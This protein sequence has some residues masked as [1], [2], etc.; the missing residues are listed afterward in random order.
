MSDIATLPVSSR[1]RR[2]N[3]P[4]LAYR[5]TPGAG[6]ALVFLPGY[7]SDMAGGKA[8]AVFD[9]AV[10]HGRACTLLD[11]SGCGESEGAFRDETL[12]SWRDDVLDVL[13]QTTHDG[14]LILIG[15]S[16]GG[17][18]MLL[19]A[20]MMPERIAGLVGI[21]PAPDFTRWGFTEAEVAVLKQDRFLNRGG[22]D[23]H[24]ATTTTLAFWEAGQANL[25]LD[26]AI[27]L[28]CPVALLHGMEDDAVPYDISLQ[29]ARQL[30]SDAVRLHLVKDGDHRLSRAQDIALLIATVAAM[31][32][33]QE[34]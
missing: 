6:P 24:D 31:P 14:P 21:A 1:L 23:A 5:H 32:F 20:R 2:T 12:E 22:A 33:G 19:I 3:R 34:D 15:S 13:A 16:M 30:R 27:P 11:Y 7:A 18:L 28:T 26:Q 10:A 4:H 8:T 9:W 25:L 17:W 29:I